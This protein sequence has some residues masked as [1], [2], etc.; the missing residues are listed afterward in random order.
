[1]NVQLPQGNVILRRWTAAL[2][3]LLVVPLAISFNARVAAI[4]QMRQDEARLKQAV[5]A[6][7]ARHADLKS[8]LGYVTSDRYVEHWARV[9][10]RMAKSGQ[11][12]VIPVA[13]GDSKSSPSVSA[14]VN[15]PASI[16]DEWWAVFFDETTNSVP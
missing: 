7:E 9:D 10:A 1:M 11:V 4:R 8:M 15:A 2:I 3:L 12:P 13:S 6:E 14:S 5:A 16:F